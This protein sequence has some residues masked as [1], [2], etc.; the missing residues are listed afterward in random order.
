[1]S[2]T[3]VCVCGWRQP[4]VVAA[5]L[6]VPAHRI[7]ATGPG[8]DPC[9]GDRD[10]RDRVHREAIRLRIE[11]VG[12]RQTAAQCVADAVRLDAMLSKVLP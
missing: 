6:T 11:A 8:T 9:P 4:V 5:T 3:V 2:A 1:M 10:A 12:H 7:P